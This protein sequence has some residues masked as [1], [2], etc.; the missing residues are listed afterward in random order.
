[1]PPPTLRDG[2][3]GPRQKRSFGHVKIRGPTAG[4]FRSIP[5]PP[6]RR[7]A[8]ACPARPLR[9]ACFPIPDQQLVGDAF[10]LGGIAREPAIGNTPARVARCG[11]LDESFGLVMPW[12][13]QNH[14]CS[15]E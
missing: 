1:M 7:R 15:I 12:R 3:N 6:A 4:G 5:P 11:Q 8:V 14:L 10:G 2:T 13:L 9:P